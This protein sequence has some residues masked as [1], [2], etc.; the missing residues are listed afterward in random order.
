MN[1]GSARRWGA[2]KLVRGVL[3]SRAPCRPLEG[4]PTGLLWEAKCCSPLRPGSGGQGETQGMCLLFPVPL[5]GRHVG[6]VPWAP[7]PFS[8][9]LGELS[10]SQREA[11]SWGTW[12]W[13]Q[14]RCLVGDCP[15]EGGRVWSGNQ[16][17]FLL[18]CRSLVL[19]PGLSPPG[20][21]LLTP[22]VLGIIF[23]LCVL[24]RAPRGKKWH[25]LLG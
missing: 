5:W 14:Q 24:V 9:A 20:L 6:Q 12:R 8:C 22:M 15:L 21:S 19:S 16:P 11:W 10:S 17:H 1:G 18:G 4:S 25:A 2:G 7:P 13:R 3:V 23:K